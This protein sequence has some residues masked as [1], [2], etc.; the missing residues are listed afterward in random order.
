M[1][2]LLHPQ[3]AQA[4]GRA[5]GSF[6]RSFR[7]LLLFRAG[8]GFGLRYFARPSLHRVGNL[9]YLFDELGP[10]LKAIPHLLIGGA[11]DVKSCMPSRKTEPDKLIVTGRAVVSISRLSRIGVASASECP[12]FPVRRIAIALPSLTL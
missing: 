12:M 7:G 6:L 9:T 8:G 5:C 4:L 2:G 3:P 1:Q 10:G 11:T